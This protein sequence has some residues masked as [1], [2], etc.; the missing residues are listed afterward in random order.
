MIKNL[1]L[2]G[3]GG[4]IGSIARFLIIQLYK[5]TSFPFATL[6]INLSG[7][8]LIGMI[9]GASI[10]GNGFHPNWKIFLSTGICGGFTTFSAFSFENMNMI[11]EGKWLMA[12]FY[13]IL[14][15]SIGIAAS[16]V[17]YK[18]TA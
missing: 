14:S 12:F 8:L 9:I 1:L 5:T 2:V 13:I 4:A 10:K 3:L 16:Y 18:L 15:V 11:V 17:G 7:S 6:F